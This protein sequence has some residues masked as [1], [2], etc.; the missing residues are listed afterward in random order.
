MKRLDVMQKPEGYHE[1]LAITGLCYHAHL[2]PSAYERVRTF[3]E[4]LS[5][6][7]TVAH[8]VD[9]WACAEYRAGDFLLGGVKV[10]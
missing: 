7:C 1:H 9:K 2:L 5:I 10:R 3:A 4:K 6:G 8:V